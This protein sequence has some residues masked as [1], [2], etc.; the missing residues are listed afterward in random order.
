MKIN[1]ANKDDNI[2]IS[3]QH[4]MIFIVFTNGKKNLYKLSSDQGI[5]RESWRWCEWTVNKLSVYKQ[6]DFE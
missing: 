4:R 2:L 6:K 1:M 3:L 5:D